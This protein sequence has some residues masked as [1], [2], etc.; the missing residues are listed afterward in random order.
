MANRGLLLVVPGTDPKVDIVFVHGLRADMEKTWTRDKVFWPAQLLPKELPEARI[1]LFGYDSSIVG[2]RHGTVAQTEIRSNADDL[3]S[4]LAAERAKEPEAA[5][6]PL[7]IVAHSLGGLVA[8]QLFN[9]GEQS[10]DDTSA[11]AIVKNIR[12]LIFLGTP[13]QGSVPAGPAESARKILKLLGV[14]TQEHTLKMLGANSESINSLTRTFSKLL[15]KRRMSKSAEDQISAFFFYETL[16]TR[17]GGI[18]YIQVRP[19]PGR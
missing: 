18:R 3:C 2:L 5:N 19:D 1:F 9:D 7:I 4:K 11:K 14:E 10:S 13:F 15:N 12:G 17:V 8:T 6:R 16:T